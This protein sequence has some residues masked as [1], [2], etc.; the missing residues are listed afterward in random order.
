MNLN[1]KKLLE[2]MEEKSNSI[3]GKKVYKIK[4]PID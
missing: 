3:L 4:Y 1:I 2:I